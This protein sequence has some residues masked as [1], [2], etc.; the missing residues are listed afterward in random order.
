[1]TAMF[2]IKFNVGTDETDATILLSTVL[3]LITVG[4]AIALTS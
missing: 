1:M 3:S 4:V 2:A